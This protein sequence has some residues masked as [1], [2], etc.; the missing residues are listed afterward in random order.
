MHKL[1]N[2]FCLPLCIAGSIFLSSG[3]LGYTSFD[4]NKEASTESSS[5]INKLYSE[6]EITLKDPPVS[7]VL[8]EKIIVKIR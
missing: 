6:K 2:L 4:V 5:Q 1:L 8:S 7:E 3:I